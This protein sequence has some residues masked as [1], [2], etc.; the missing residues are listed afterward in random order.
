MST[1]WRTV[2]VFISST[3]RDMH[4]ERDHLVRVVFPELKE[5]CRK[6]HIQLIDVD[7]RWGVTEEQA[8]GGGALDICLDEI[9][10]C[11]PYFLG[12]LGH[13]YGYVP[14]GHDHSITAQEVY[15]GVLHNNLP[16][17]LIDLRPFVEGILEGRTL[18]KE[19]VSCLVRCYQWDPEKRKYLVQK[20]ITP[21]DQKILRSI[22]DV[23][24]IYQK[25]RSFFFFRA[26]SLTKKLAGSNT[27][28]YFEADEAVKG[29]LA[30]LKQE[31]I[32]AGL[33][34]F[35]Y[36]DLE[37]FG[38]R[39]LETLWKR[40]DAEF[41]EKREEIARDWLEEEAEFHELFMAGRTRRFVGRSNI[42]KRMQTFVE[43]DADPRLMVITGEPGCGKSALMA[44][45]T[46]EVIREH[47]D[48]LILSHFV[49]A[50]PSSASLRRTLRRLCSQ[51]NRALG[52][53]EEVPEE[54]KELAQL[55]PELLRRA[56]ETRHILLVIDA[57]DQ[58]E[59]TDNAHAMRWLPPKLPQYV[60]VMVSTLAGEALDALRSWQIQPWFEELSGLTEPDIE[61]FVTSYMGEIRKDFPSKK[62]QEAFYDKVNA[63]NPLYILVALE[64][65]R[66]FPVYE[67]VG[68][69]VASLPDTV[70]EL[71]DQVLERVEGDFSRPLV[72]DFMS[73]IAC[74]RQG[75]SSEELQTLLREYAPAFDPSKSPTK[76]PDMLFSRLRR[77]F[78][79]YL[80]ERSG[81][82]DFFHG[83][84]KEA[85]GER[86]L[87]EEK[88]RDRTHQIIADYFEQRWAE[89]YLRALDELP[90]QLIKTKDWA[91][92]E[93]ILCDLHFIEAKCVAGM[94]YDLMGDYNAALRYGLPQRQDS[95][96][97]FANFIRGQSH[98]LL[99]CP[100]LTFQQAANEPADTAPAQAA[101]RLLDAGLENHPW[102]RWM[103]K[104]QCNTG[105]LIT[106]EGHTSSVYCC[107]VSR[108]GEMVASAGWDGLRLWN[109]HTGEALHTGSLIVQPAGFVQ[110]TDQGLWVGLRNPN[111]EIE[112]MKL[113][114]DVSWSVL[115]EWDMNARS[116]AMSADGKY[117]AFSDKYLDIYDV[118]T[119]KRH[120]TLLPGTDEP[121][122]ELQ[123]S[124]ASNTSLLAAIARF[125]KLCIWETGNWKEQ[126]SYETSVLQP[127]SC[128]LSPDGSIIV[129][130]CHKGFLC[131]ETKT[132]RVIH[133]DRSHANAVEHCCFNHDGSLLVSCSRDRLVKV[134]NMSKWKN[135]RE[136]V[137]LTV[138]EDF[139]VLYYEHLLVHSRKTEH[140]AVAAC[141]LAPDGSVMALSYPEEG[142]V[143]LKTSNLS[144]QN[145][146]YFESK[147]RVTALA[148]SPDGKRNAFG[149]ID[150]G[151]ELR[152][153]ISSYTQP[154][155]H[156]YA[157]T[158]CAFSPD[159]N[160]VLSASFDG[161]LMLSSVS[162]NQRSVTMKGHLGAVYDCGFS[163]DGETIV[164]A[165][166]DGTLRLW[167][168]R[169]RNVITLRCG[170]SAVHCS[171]FSPDGQQIA[172]GI[173]DGP[174]LIWDVV[175][176]RIVK[177]LDGHSDFIRRCYWLADDRL[178]ASASQD[179]TV[180]IWDVETGNELATFA[181]DTAITA[182]AVLTEK[183]LLLACSLD[184]RSF[185]LLPENL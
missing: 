77:A 137:A 97:D 19:Q 134:W 59:R 41:P 172:C 22:F 71:F 82:I 179:G 141:A 161:T 91:G 104:P 126:L 39:V 177:A 45:F 176:K 166:A 122:G 10:S 109:L 170:R 93:H 106:L 143:F 101:Q 145:R 12:L 138:P 54:Y 160:L 66:V 51:L 37:T 31:I 68:K 40:I 99:K 125:G 75:M 114:E 107:S 132:G 8:E 81:V 165:S 171:A 131:L 3:F 60:K 21:E 102:I 112:T 133:I 11:R 42:L 89:P 157:V 62:I 100:T 23:Y 151:V 34:Y 184:G 128:S 44:R 154:H 52:V 167:D 30:I 28:D 147:Y 79:A 95:L 4:A 185:L 156:T 152:G 169:G 33:P 181:I 49:G 103:N 6:R 92:L 153:E 124:F 175:T 96:T 43:D 7:L 173:S 87:T 69:R 111:G 164:S 1:P 158:A 168:Q 178:L 13:R 88:D 183:S 47:P 38:Q 35:Q 108:D 46:E 2:R 148:Y 27:E 105:S 26:E 57:L 98:L 84:L 118:A 80:F 15:H 144:E 163:P 113:L 94:T 32:D 155:T 74:G 149:H 120:L 65:L 174:I 63:G 85:I 58:F 159:G 130:S 76:L 115:R 53:E 121:G 140:T 182:F 64:E 116:V 129:L 136:S 110:F 29:K 72:Q 20:D 24:S 127:L 123:C 5:R 25:D 86:Y 142:V 135:D 14:P 83:Q 16:P 73:F 67:E 61:E 119:Q 78:S 18:F 48:W 70:P 55:F 50:S 150:G 146:R 9:D 139:K 36:D 56:S 117:A 17:Q 90:H 180:R 162:A